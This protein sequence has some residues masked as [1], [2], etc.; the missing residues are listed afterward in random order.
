MQILLRKST[1]LNKIR[2]RYDD[3][4]QIVIYLTEPGFLR[5]PHGRRNEG[6]FLSESVLPAGAISGSV[7]SQKP[8]LLRVISACIAGQIVEWYDYGL[9]GLLAAEIGKAFFSSGD[10]AAALL[11]A[12]AVFG[13]SFVVR[14]FGGVIMGRLGDLRGRKAVLVASLL[15]M[16]GSTAMVGLLPGTA[17]AGIWAPILLVLARVLQG[18]SA[19]GEAPAAITYVTEYVPQ[20]RR[21]LFCGLL[22]SGNSAGFLLA[23]AIIWLLRS[24]CTD[25]QFDAWAWRVPFLFALPLGLIGFYIRR[26][27][28]ESNLYE[29]LRRNRIIS[30][31]PLRDVLLCAPGQLAQ[32]IGIG[33]LSFIANYLLLSYM[34][35]H[36]RRLGLSETLISQVALFATL[37]LL[38]AYPLMGALS[39]IIGRRQQLIG[40]AAF[41]AVAG[42][43][44]FAAMSAA[45]TSSI[46]LC[47]SLFALGTAAYISV[48][49]VMYNE[50]LDQSRR[51]TSYSV[52]FNLSGALFGGTSLWG[53]AKLVSITTDAR[54]PALYLI[55]AALISLSSLL[56]I[57]TR[58]V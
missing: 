30:S 11:S 25:Q 41:F 23:T 18:I 15:L 13:V 33:A 29:H 49:G 42:W 24:L 46:V 45:G 12:F 1:P 48:L 54:A 37:L 56:S 8:A 26:R 39:D 5:N 2:L 16:T 34:P 6:N 53:S 14:P 38:M 21:G 10:P 28:D 40:A 19:A 43:P 22:L 9:Y 50:F 58:T 32:S 57:R 51:M 52:G 31:T 47:M 20:H 44:L 55:A 3:Y 4:E 35:T 36:F 17:T 7:A 27:L